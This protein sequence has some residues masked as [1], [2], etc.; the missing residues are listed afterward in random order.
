MRLKGEPSRRTCSG[1]TRG[2]GGLEGGGLLSDD[3]SARDAW[4]LAQHTR[5]VL[6]D[7]ARPNLLRSLDLFNRSPLA[8]VGGPQP[9]VRKSIDDVRRYARALTA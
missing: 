1:A 5:V 7:I 6:L 4:N 3:Y 2:G 8:L 9:D